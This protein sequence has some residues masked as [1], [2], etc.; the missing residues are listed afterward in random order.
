MSRIAA[1]LLLA[2]SLAACGMIDTLVDGWKHTKAVEND[3][4]MSTGMKPRVGFD[5]HNGRLERVTVTF[6]K[7]YEA[8]PL[9]ALAETVR[10]SVTS[11][12]KQT[13]RD[14]VLGFSLG[15]APAGTAAQLSEPP[16]DAQREAL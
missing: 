12:F 9:D 1:I 8:K 14:I 13:P 7:L 4:E 10:H 5:W 15:A 11:E 3:L 2:I 16:A 6:P